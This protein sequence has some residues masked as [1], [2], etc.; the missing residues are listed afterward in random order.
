MARDGDVALLLEK[1]KKYQLWKWCVKKGRRVNSYRCSQ[2]LLS[3]SMADGALVFAPP[4]CDCGLR[5]NH[6]HGGWC[7]NSIG[8]IKKQQLWK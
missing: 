4:D 2:L 6:G 8:K 5:S 1:I 7:N 3:L